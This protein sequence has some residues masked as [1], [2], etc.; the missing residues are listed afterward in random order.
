VGTISETNYGYTNQEVVPDLGLHANCAPL[1]VANGVDYNA[2]FYDRLLG[3]FIQA[4]TIVPEPGGS[5]GWNRYS[6]VENNPI[7]FIDFTGNFAVW[8]VI[9]VI[10][11][12]I[13]YGWTALDLVDSAIIANDPNS[14]YSD[15]QFAE[16]NILLAAGTEAIP[17][18]E[19]F[20]NL[21]IDDILR[22]RLLK[23][24]R[25]AFEKAGTNGLKE[26]IEKFCG[27][28]SDEV[29][30]K[31]G[32][33]DVNFVSPAI[34]KKK[35]FEHLDEFRIRG[36]INTSPEEYLAGARQ[37][38]KTDGVLTFIRPSDN[39]TLYFYRP[40]GEFLVVHAD[41]TLGTYFIP[42]RGYQ[43]WLDEINR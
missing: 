21:P 14:S 30:R 34:L 42:D 6:Y 10:A 18:D 27:K 22:R 41:N 28:H 25:E 31:L 13:D 43:Y 36:I 35:Y 3:R 11:A 5:Q 24:A 17:L 33:Y 23:G 26:F 37:L 4:D 16:L 20:I 12:A 8:A 1:S 7:N 39:A 40:T 19:L 9:R 2:R 15:I 29:L 32:F 38:M